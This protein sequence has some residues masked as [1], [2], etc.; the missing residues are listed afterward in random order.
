MRAVTSAEDGWESQGLL[1]FGASS[2]K[3]SESTN[4]RISKSLARQM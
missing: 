2:Q 1:I 3:I 4:Q